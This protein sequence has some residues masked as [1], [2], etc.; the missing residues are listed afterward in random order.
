VLDTRLALERDGVKRRLIHLVSRGKEEVII[1]KQ[2][3]KLLF[4]QVIFGELSHYL[5][6]LYCSPVF[7]I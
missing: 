7:R 2:N 1:L 4:K 5:R 3:L 6:E